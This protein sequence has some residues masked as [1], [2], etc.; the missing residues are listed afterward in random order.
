M[1]RAPKTK[2]TVPRR[3]PVPPELYMHPDKVVEMACKEEAKFIKLMK[4]NDVKDFT[5]YIGFEAGVTL[6]SG[7]KPFTTT[8]NP[9]VFAL[10]LGKQELCAF[11]LKQSVDPQSLL[12]TYP[13]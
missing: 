4:D 12:K 8:W 6:A 10:V 1:Q 7:L 3:G 5:P 13:H 11:I 2:G 9:L